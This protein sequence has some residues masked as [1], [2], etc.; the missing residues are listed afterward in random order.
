MALRSASVASQEFGKRKLYNQY[1]AAIS[2]HIEICYCFLC[3]LDSLEAN[4]GE[5]CFVA[6]VYNLTI[7]SEHLPESSRVK[8]FVPGICKPYV[9]ICR[10]L[11][12]DVLFFHKFLLGLQ[13]IKFLLKIS[14]FETLD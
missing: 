12:F 7:W 9:D 3:L 14:H 11:C 2:S 4:K 5:L 8:Q 10:L 13:L 6:D 1:C